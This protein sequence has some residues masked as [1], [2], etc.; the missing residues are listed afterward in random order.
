MVG[1]VGRTRGGGG[2]ER[3]GLTSGRPRPRAAP[4]PQGPWEAAG[5]ERGPPGSRP[6]RGSPTPIPR[7]ALTGRFS[8]FSPKFLPLGVAGGPGS[9]LSRDPPRCTSDTSLEGTPTDPPNPPEALCTFPRCE[10]LPERPPLIFPRLLQTPSYASNIFLREPPSG[11]RSPNLLRPEIFPRG[12]SSYS[13][14]M[15][16][17]SS[18]GTSLVSPKNLLQIRDSPKSP[19]DPVHSRNL[20]QRPAS[21]IPTVSPRLPSHTSQEF[22]LPPTPI[23][24]IALEIFH[25]EPPNLRAPPLGILQNAPDVP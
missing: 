3:A 20:P 18:P 23:P 15:Y 7:V 5:A 21:H 25:S 22:S 1:R 12:H 14:D 11:P 10:R 6:S 19:P 8:S 17:I 24:E 9:S 2:S 4:P 13:N 16:Q